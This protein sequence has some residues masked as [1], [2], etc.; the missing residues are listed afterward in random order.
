M[1]RLPAIAIILFSTILMQWHSIAFWYQQTGAIG[2]A[3]SLAI[4]GVALWFWWRRRTVLAVLA[5]VLLVAGPLHELSA[6]VLD[7]ISQGDERAHLI[8]LTRDEIAQLTASIEQ[9]ETNSGTRTGWSGRI[10]RTQ[11]ALDASRAKL[12]ELMAQDGAYLEWRNQAII[13]VQVLVLLVVLTGQVQAVMSLRLDKPTPRQPGT[14]QPYRIKPADM[15][16]LPLVDTRDFDQRVSDVVARMR[17]LLPR[18]ANRQR[19]LADHFGFRPA[20]VSMVMNHA[21]RKAEGREIVSDRALSRMEQ[22]LEE[23]Q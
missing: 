18:F 1:N 12:A 19:Q 5:S 2:V 10:D 20:D 14:R 11:S 21:A 23:K 17:E 13:G 22:A 3:W 8:E 7:S 16:N 6:P 4:E 9:Y 15:V